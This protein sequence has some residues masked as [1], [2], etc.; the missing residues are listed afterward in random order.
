MIDK[1]TRFNLLKPAPP[2][3][4][5]AAKCKLKEFFL[6]LKAEH[7]LM[8]AELKMVN[9]E[10]RCTTQ[11]QFEHVNPFDTVATLRDHIESL[12]AQEQLTCLDETVTQKYGDIF[13][14]ITHIDELPTSVQ[15]YMKLKDPNTTIAM[16]S[17][18]TPCKYKE[19]WN[20]L[21]QQHLDTGSLCPSNSKH[22]FHTFLIPK[23]DVTVLLCWVNDYCML[24]S[25]TIT[26]LH[27]LPCINDI[28]ADCAKAKIWSV[29]DMTISFF[30][31]CIH[32]DDIHLTAVTTPLGFYE[33]LVMP[34][35]LWNSPAIHQ[36]CVTKALCAY[37]GIFI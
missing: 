20:I 10:W 7:A 35:G 21:I 31:T 8:L 13:V 34:M 5:T 18:S 27:P 32:P 29:M 28:L 26:D 30:Q 22:A 17:Y 23:T 25:N 24:N 36:H 2:P 6:D 11:H 3:L 37:I 1:D 4:P 15:C 19:A 16:C 14:P 9:V 33:W 12:T